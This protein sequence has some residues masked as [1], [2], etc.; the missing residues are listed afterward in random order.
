MCSS[1]SASQIL[2]VACYNDIK[3]KSTALKHQRNSVNMQTSSA[4]YPFDS[5]RLLMKV[6]L[7]SSHSTHSLHSACCK[8]LIEEAHKLPMASS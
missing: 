8:A 7:Y 4:S 5:R 3:P 1:R 6:R 2:L